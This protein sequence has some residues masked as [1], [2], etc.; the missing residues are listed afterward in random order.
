MA[1]VYRKTLCER[2]SCMIVANVVPR[3]PRSSCNL[4]NLRETVLVSATYVGESVKGRAVEQPARERGRIASAWSDGD[5][6]GSAKT[7]TS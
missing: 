1:K 3:P 6:V 2:R 5:G 7:F 4:L